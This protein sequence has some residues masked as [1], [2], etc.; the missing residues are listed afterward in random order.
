M[1][2]VAVSGTSERFNRLL[3]HMQVRDCQVQ[4]VDDPAEA[5]ACLFDLDGFGAAELLEQQRRQNPQ[6]PILLLAVQPPAQNALPW[7]QKPLQP[8]RI[9][10]ALRQLQQRPLEAKGDSDPR[11]EPPRKEGKKGGKFTFRHYEPSHYLQGLLS[12][13]YRKALATGLVL[14]L[15][16]G[17]EPILIF[18][19]QEVVWVDADDRK[20][21]AFCRLSLKKFSRVTGELNQQPAIEP[22]PKAQIARLPSGAQRMDAFLWKVAWWNA[23]GRLPTS[24]RFS[25]TLHL[26]RWPNLSRYWHSA[27]ALRIAASWYRRDM[28]PELLIR[29]FGAGAGSDVASFVSACAALGLISIVKEEPPPGAEKPASKPPEG[30]IK[31]ILQRLRK[32]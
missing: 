1:M 13:A 7:L 31:R 3:R 20:L 9:S 23:A 17:W 25:Q 8:E 26:K 4:V 28:S 32:A 22:D 29:V 27:R 14:R 21:Q 24:I 6:L 30:L 11:P 15:E 18:P 19:R 12:R 5:D 2:K 10:K 16:T